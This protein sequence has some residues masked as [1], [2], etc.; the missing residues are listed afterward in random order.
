MENAINELFVLGEL[1]AFSLLFLNA[2]TEENRV[3]KR[4]ALIHCNPCIVSV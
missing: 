1:H 3:I 4:F 2:N